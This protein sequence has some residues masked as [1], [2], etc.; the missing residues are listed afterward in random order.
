MGGFYFLHLVGGSAL[1]SQI[2][3]VTCSGLEES[4]RA[5][6]RGLLPAPSGS[7]PQAQDRVPRAEWSHEPGQPLAFLPGEAGQNFK[8]EQLL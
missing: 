5:D 4:G 2:R 1:T 7:H 8:K 6:R 3:S